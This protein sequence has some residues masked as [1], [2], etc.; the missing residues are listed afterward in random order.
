MLPGVLFVGKTIHTR[1]LTLGDG[2]KHTL[3]FREIAAADFRKLQAAKNDEQSEL[4]VSKVIA[5]SLCEP[6]GSDAITAEEAG[7]IKTGIRVAISLAIAE[8]NGIGAN[9]GKASP[10][11]ALNGSGTS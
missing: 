8:V 5:A 9:V 7:N 11:E 2:E 10:P 1:E 6:D 4:A 3:Y